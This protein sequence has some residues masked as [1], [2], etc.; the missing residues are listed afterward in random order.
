MT[1]VKAIGAKSLTK[2]HGVSDKKYLDLT[3]ELFSG[4]MDPYGAGNLTTIRVITEQVKASGG[5]R[6]E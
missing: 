4:F 2:Y 6:F 5:D 3:Q 1:E